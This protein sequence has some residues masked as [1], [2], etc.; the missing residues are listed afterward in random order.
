MRKYLVLTSIFALSAC[1]GGGGSGDFGGHAAHPTTPGNPPIHMQG[2]SGGQTVHANNATLTNM[3]SYTVDYGTDEDTTKQAMIDYVNTHLGNSR[4]ISQDRSATRS[5]SMRARDGEVDAEEFARADAAIT[6]MKQVL[7][8]M[9]GKPNNAALR[10]YVT[11]YRYAVVNAL[12]MQDVDVTN[13]TSIDDLVAAF[14][15]LKSD[16]SW[17]TDN[18]MAN[19]DE[20]DATKFHIT[21]F[22]MEDNVKLHDA[23]DANAYFQFDL[24][25]GGTITRVALFEGDV[26]NDYGWFDKNNNPNGNQFVKT[27]YGYRFTM[28]NLATDTPGLTES[29]I[30]A[31][32]WFNGITGKDD[33]TNLRFNNDDSTLTNSAKKAAM[34][35]T[36]NREFND[37]KRGQHDHEHDDDIELVRA[38]YLALINAAF[39]DLE[40]DGHDV[41]FGQQVTPLDLTVT[42]IGEGKN[43]HLQYSDF[44]YADLKDVHE[45]SNGTFKESHTYVPYAGGYDARIVNPEEDVTFT[46]TAVAG[47]QWS[48]KAANGDEDGDG[49][50]VRNENAQL[51]FDHTTGKSTLVMNNL[52]NDA[53]KKW[54]NVTV[55]GDFSGDRA[56]DLRFE[57]DDTGKTTDAAYD[58]ISNPEDIS[59]A[60]EDWNESDNL[61]KQTNSL[62][63]TIDYRGNAR[64]D[65]YGDSPTSAPGEVTSTFSFSEEQHINDGHGNED[66]HEI[67]IYGAYGGH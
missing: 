44:G 29:Q 6:E 64:V 34:I 52:V 9:V 46:G 67:G 61:F 66:H 15:T 14:N 55:S 20:F 57:F 59:F 5:S 28:G 3:S 48:T 10:T 51:T 26:P 12:K 38:Q 32:T 36:I 39:T 19:L 27:T 30:A 33:I 21:K 54:Y 40:D 23:G 8:D 62:D 31:F 4:G 45:Q 1:G 41:V 53:G 60:A 42:M 2:F 35:Q 16:K 49:M 11:R 24:D 7:Y 47:I 13:E 65:Y 50:L 56:A 25:S 18:I 58:F 43:L 63:D 37:F 22:R 17:T